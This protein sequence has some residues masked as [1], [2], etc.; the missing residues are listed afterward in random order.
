MSGYRFRWRVFLVV[1]LFC[2]EGYCQSK[3]PE[4]LFSE[5]FDDTLNLELWRAEIEPVGESAVFTRDGQLILNTAGGVTVWFTQKLEGNIRIEYD[6]TV[7]VEGEKNDRLS[8]LN[9]FWMATDPPNANLFTRSGKFEDYDS[10]SLYYVGFG[11][12]SNTTTRFRKY[13]GN[14]E[15][16]LLQEFKDKEH[17]L[18][19]NHRYHITI[20]VEDGRTTF[21]VDDNVIFDW[22]DKSP[23]RQGYF[24]FRSTASRHAI[25]HFRVWKSL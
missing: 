19:P 13:H 14:G 23:L 12:N 16:P 8:D 24:A 17:L 7:L 4:L 9:Q 11:G 25:D 1:S 3:K 18:K 20:K 10:L 5:N 6:W 15:K 22:N 2:L 21:S